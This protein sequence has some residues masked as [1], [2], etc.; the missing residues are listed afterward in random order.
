MSDTTS[1]PVW[2][3][4]AVVAGLLALALTA[5]AAIAFAGQAKADFSSAKCGGVNTHANGASFAR[6]A[7]ESF[8]SYFKSFYCSGSGLSVAYNANGSGAGLEGAQLRPPAETSRFWGSDDPPTPGQVALMNAGAKKETVD[9]KPKIVADGVEGNEGKIHVFPVA[10]GA[11]APLV[12][13]PE[14]CN[15]EALADKYRTV[16]AAQITG[17][18]ALKGILRVRFTKVK[19]EKVWAGEENAKWSEAFPELAAQGAPCEVPI[20]RVVRF[21]KSGTTFGFKDYLRTIKPDRG[22][23]TTFESGTGEI[24]NREWPNAAFGPRADCPGKEGPG[25]Q[26]NSIDFLTSGCENGNG[27]LVK[28][29]IAT[30]GSIGYSDI[31][32]ARNASPTLA[33]NASLASAPT[34]PYWTQVQ[35]GSVTVGSPQE[36]QGNGFTEPTLDEAN[37]FRTTAASNPSQKGANCISATI[38]KGTPG[39]SFG[40]WSKTSGVNAA[41][42]FGICTMTYVMAFDDNAPVF[43][44]TAEQ[45]GKARTVKDYLESVVTDAAQ[46]QLTAADYAPLPPNMLALARTAIGQIGWNKSS[47]G[48]GGNNPGGG[49]NPG[50]G[51]PGTGGGG[52]SVITPPVVSNQFSIPKKAIS[53]KTGSVTFSVKLPGAGKL[54]VLGTTKVG[55]KSIKVGTVTLTVGKAGTYSVT[56]KPTGAAKQMLSEDGSLKVNLTFTFSPVGG[57]AKSTNSAVTLKLT[58]KRG[59]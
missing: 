20:I 12:N 29:L 49:G 11:I 6:G 38:F 28:K 16:S 44:N 30:D 4:R 8:N 15:P 13:F 17:N 43:G 10:A 41:S 40:D 35:N 26:D 42:G 57:A 59:K 33:V 3:A 2:G 39:D 34:T 24:G 14:G 32:T 7:Q 9:G 46:A 55:K 45:E 52:G 37:G 1:A 48:G 25:S 47:S 19:F 54:G 5:L 56:L 21:D 22:W 23:T 31:A 50:G 53:S 18:A 51:N 36:G 27:E 58:Q